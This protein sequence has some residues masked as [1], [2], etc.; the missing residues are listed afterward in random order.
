MCG[1]VITWL[2][3]P[4]EPVVTA[5]N[6]RGPIVRVS[7][8]KLPAATLSVP[9]RLLRQARLKCTLWQRSHQIKTQ[10]LK[11][12]KASTCYWLEFLS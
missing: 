12:Q 10:I 1:I 6:H 4:E 5:S 2:R 3:L 9:M 11:K 8:H 7:P